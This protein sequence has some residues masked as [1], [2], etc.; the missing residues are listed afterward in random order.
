MTPEALNESIRAEITGR[1]SVNVDDVTDAIEAR[2]SNSA[3]V[4]LFRHLMRHYVA[5]RIGRERT[6]LVLRPQY[7]D[8]TELPGSQSRMSGAGHEHLESH[9]GLAGAR[10]AEITP[11]PSR[12]SHYVSNW[13]A[14]LDDLVTIDKDGTRK[15]FALCTV[16]DVMVVLGDTRAQVASYQRKVWFLE[17]VLA[18]MK[19]SG[20]T[21]V[22]QIPDHIYES[23][24]TANAKRVAA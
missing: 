10:H 2:L 7:D 24:V 16:D 4:K 11:G 14:K 5:Y 6:P 15:R 22:E 17:D 1:P 18:S 23:V 9:D 3:K 19:A 21:T 20:A 12:M 13:R 8:L